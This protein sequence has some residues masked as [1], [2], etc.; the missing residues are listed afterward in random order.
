MPQ[1]HPRTENSRHDNARTERSRG[2]RAAATNAAS[3]PYGEIG[4]RSVESGL[5]M[6]TEMAE[7][8][9]EIGREWFARATSKAELALDLPNKLTNAHTLPDA[10][11]A[12]QEWLGEWMSLIGEDGRHFLTD[13]RKIMDTGV[14]CFSGAMPAGS[15]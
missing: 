2:E 14:R 4:A 12:Y 10:F 7:V 5:R 15:S 13:S 6:H 3:M 1:D 9:Q 8:L 11:Y